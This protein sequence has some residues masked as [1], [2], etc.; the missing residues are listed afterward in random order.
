MPLITLNYAPMPHQLDLHTDEARF[1]VVVG[2]RR[3]GKT[4][5]SFQ[6]LLKY[7]LSH[8]DSLCWWVSPTYNEAREVG[9]SEF[10]YYEEQLAPAISLANKSLM[11][12]VFKNG[13]KIYFKG[14]DRRDSL[15]GRGIDFLSADEIAFL[16]EDT[17]RKVLRPALADKQGKAVLTTT[18]N[19]RNWFHHMYVEVTRR[20][21]TA[22]KTFH[23]TSHENLLLTDAEIED[24][25]QDLSDLDFRQEILAE[26]IT[27]AGQVYDDFSM[28]N[29]LE[30][31]SPDRNVDDIYIG[32]D[33]G[34]ANP[35]AFTFMAVNRLSGKVIQFA[36]II[37]SHTKIQVFKDQI[38]EILNHYRIPSKEV[39]FYTD[40]AGNGDEITSGESPVDYLRKFFTVINKGS[41]I[42]PG[43]SLVRKFVRNA[44]GVRKFFVTKNCPITISSLY[45]YT[46]ANPTKNNSSIKEEPLKDG[47]NDHACDAIRYF[48][49]NAFSQNRYVADV[50][51]TSSYLLETTNKPIIKRC[52]I[53]NNPF[54]SKTPKD[55]PPFACP[56]CSKEQT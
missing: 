34:Y 52:G 28:D 42:A 6:E 47:I 24:M 37:K 45:G 51:D 8:K 29:I 11:R 17:W 48:F 25:R 2:G 49:V 4:K 56:Y 12:V 53:C 21:A 10:E 35:A 43:V 18:P 15:R 16:D 31:Y 54:V 38:V 39:V 20:V 26:F 13:A 46:Y 36:E 5:S 3:S 19:G 40:P 23:W 27:K 44:A 33:F 30:D 32:C 1:K 50:P 9:Y 41:K 14:A 55:R 22:Y 7:A